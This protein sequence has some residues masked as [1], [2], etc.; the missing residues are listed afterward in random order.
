MHW[1]VVVLVGSAHDHK[2]AEERACNGAHAELEGTRGGENGIGG[3][4][5]KM[6]GRGRYY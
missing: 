1:S 4:R 3:R 6:A 2:Q 5:T